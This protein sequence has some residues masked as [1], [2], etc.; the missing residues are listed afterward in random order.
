MPYIPIGH[1]KYDLLPFC[2]EHGGEV[3]SYSPTDEIDDLLPDGET[4][5]PFGYCSYEEYFARLEGYAVKYG[6]KDGK[7]NQLG[8]KIAA[9][10]EDIRQRNVKEDWSIVQYLGK[11][12]CGI[13]G[14]T[15]G[16]YYYW[17]C[18][19]E[20]P[21]YEG[22]IDD[23]EFTSYLAW[24]RS[25]N[26]TFDGIRFADWMIAEDPTGMAARTLSGT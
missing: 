21:E 19:I 9:Y 10:I 12:T 11:S 1:E 26:G 13:G 6:T 2:R 20:N 3:F 22:V 14:F 17:P 15:H 18:S 24:G 25:D 7:P 16:R 5:I 4:I 23:E 8:L